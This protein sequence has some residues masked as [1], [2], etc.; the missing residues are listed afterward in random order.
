MTVRVYVPTTLDGLASLADEGVLAPTPDAVVAPDDDEETEYDAMTTAAD[1]LSGPGR[2]I[3][4][5]AE[6]DDPDGPVRLA[7]V[8]AVHADDTDVAV[9]GEDLGWYAVSEIEVLLGRV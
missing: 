4:V 9:P 7:Q 2:R 6:V 3:V 8:V 1:T 5:V